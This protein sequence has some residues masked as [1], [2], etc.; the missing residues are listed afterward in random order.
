DLQAAKIRE[1]LEAVKAGTQKRARLKDELKLNVDWDYSS[2]G[3]D[4]LRT[5]IR[6]MDAWMTWP[7]DATVIR[8]RITGFPADIDAFR[9]SI[10]EQL[11]EMY[12]RQLRQLVWQTRARQKKISI[13]AHAGLS[14][15]QTEIDTFYAQNKDSFFKVKD[16]KAEVL[17]LVI[18]SMPSFKGA[19]RDLTKEE[20]ARRTQIQFQYRKR[21][22]E[23][24]EDELQ[25]R[26]E[27]LQAT[28]PGVPLAMIKGFKDFVIRTRAEAPAAAAVAIRP[29]FEKEITAGNLRITERSY[30]LMLKGMAEMP[31]GGDEGS[32][33]AERLRMRLA[34]PS[35]GAAAATLVPKLELVDR[36]TRAVRMSFLTAESLGEEYVI[37]KSDTRVLKIVRD[38]VVG[39]RQAYA[40]RELA[41]DFLYPR[42]NAIR[43][44]L[45]DEICAG[46][47]F[48]CLRSFDH[49]RAVQFLFP[50]KLVDPTSAL[51]G[52]YG[53]VSS[54]YDNYQ[55][56]GSV[57]EISLSAL[58][59]VFGYPN[60]PRERDF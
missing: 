43:L 53:P 33:D 5:L 30:A 48:P 38:Q 47:D 29:E 59:V 10:F 49:I 17:D 46:T 1:E 35:R 6:Q 44:E 51:V 39:K 12:A 3:L 42:D 58:A 36:E 2:N 57:K 32:L 8:F 34:F 21:L 60:H 18:D 37:E 4:N 28:E 11:N 27:K 13:L 20:R 24:L 54:T 16:R 31:G 40:F 23:A 56:L 9:T 45:V 15:P 55:L 50:E 26:V 22:N 52:E 14:I 25:R 41:A 7:D 19:E